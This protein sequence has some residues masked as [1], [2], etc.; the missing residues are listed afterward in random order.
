MTVVYT[1]TQPVSGGPYLGGV[2]WGSNYWPITMPFMT[3]Q[4]VSSIEVYEC[5]I[6]FAYGTTTT[7]GCENTAGLSAQDYENA[8]MNSLIGIPSGTSFHS[9][10]F[11]NTWQF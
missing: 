2:M 8:V 9:D 10:S 7:T 11:F 3:E 4:K 6:D 1:P 5:D